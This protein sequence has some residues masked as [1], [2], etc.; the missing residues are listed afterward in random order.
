MK[1]SINNLEAYAETIGKPAEKEPPFF[2]PQEFNLICAAV[3]H[4]IRHELVRK[5][6]ETPRQRR[7]RGLWK[8]TLDNAISKIRTLNHSDNEKL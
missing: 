3:R 5:D 4:Y 7:R 8:H 2:T 6:D 1:V